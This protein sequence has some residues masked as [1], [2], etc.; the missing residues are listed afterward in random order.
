MHIRK[1]ASKARSSFSITKRQAAAKKAQTLQGTQ[2][3]EPSTENTR[4]RVQSETNAIYIQQNLKFYKDIEL[5]FRS[6]TA[7][8]AAQRYQSAGLIILIVEKYGH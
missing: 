7:S 3:Y 6:P 4:G 2:V 8:S 1:D 5:K